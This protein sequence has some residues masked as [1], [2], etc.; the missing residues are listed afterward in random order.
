MLVRKSKTDNNFL[1]SQSF[2]NVS[3][4]LEIDVS[5]SKVSFCSRVDYPLVFGISASCCGK[6][7]CIRWLAG[8][9][10]ELLEEGFESIKRGFVFNIFT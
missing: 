3:R 6:D 2:S 9:G 1:I 4:S 5:I 10:P 7:T 8:A